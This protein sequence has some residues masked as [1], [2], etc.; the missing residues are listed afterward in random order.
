MNIA[1]LKSKYIGKF[2]TVLLIET[3]PSRY[4]KVGSIGTPGTKIW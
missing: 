4:G 2:L 3:P 1:G